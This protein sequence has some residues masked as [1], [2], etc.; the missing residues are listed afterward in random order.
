MLH[1]LLRKVSSIELSPN[2]PPRIVLEFPNVTKE[3]KLQSSKT[4]RQFFAEIRKE[5]EFCGNL[6]VLVNENP[7]TEDTLLGTLTKEEFTLKIDKEEIHVCPG[8]AALVRGNE[9]Y[10]SKC[11]DFGVPFNEAR[12]ISRFLEALDSQLSDT[13]DDKTL[14]KAL[15][16]AKSLS[17]T[18]DLEEKSILTSQLN[19]FQQ[20]LEMLE[21]KFE[22]IKRKAEKHADLYV[23]I[24]LGVM[25]TQ[26]AG[27][28]Y[29]TFVLYGWDVMEPFSY[30]VGSTW[31]VLGFSF[32]MK[33]REEFYPASFHEIIYRKKLKK[34]MIKNKLNF[35][36]I[37]LLKKNIEIIKREIEELD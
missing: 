9:N 18:F 10:Y 31:A 36:R 22:E 25:T 21:G 30:M 4:I 20:K 17:S 5:A 7:V 15:Q 1:K 26:W 2:V 12:T 8:T 28:G 23:K 3:F 37:D 29:G 32:F 11:H 35:E 19:S 27:I 33:Q 34:L 16:N 14:G 24:G 13:F 6:M